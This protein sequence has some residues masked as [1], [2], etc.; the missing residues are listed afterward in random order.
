[1]YGNQLV[2]ARMC[3]AMYHQ[4]RSSE[5][6]LPVYQVP[7][8]LLEQSLSISS[9]KHHTCHELDNSN[10]DLGPVEQYRPFLLNKMVS[11]SHALVL[12]LLGK[13]V[14]ESFPYQSLYI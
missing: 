12:S 8:Q 14:K 9:L 10:G 6:E 11:Y 2:L 3:H 7:S 5:H 13:S 4:S 1:M